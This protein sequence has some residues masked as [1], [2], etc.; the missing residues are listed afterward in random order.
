MP[1][2]EEMCCQISKRAHQLGRSQP[3]EGDLLV[4]QTSR[5]N[6]LAREVIPSESH[7][8]DL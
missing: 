5:D 6:G 8:G 7:P 2:V 3:A 1:H 4:V